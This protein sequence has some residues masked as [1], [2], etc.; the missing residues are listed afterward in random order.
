MAGECTERRVF[1]EHGGR[2]EA[3][4]E[5]LPNKP[6]KEGL[7]EEVV[8]GNCSKVSF[9]TGMTFP[10]LFLD[11]RKRWNVVSGGDPRA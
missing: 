9:V 10:C 11:G 4:R 3:S 7:R 8:V 1:L 5:Q 6:L 2:R